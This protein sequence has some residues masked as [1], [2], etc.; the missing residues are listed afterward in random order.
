MADADKDVAG[1]IAPPPLIYVAGFALGWLLETRWPSPPLPAPAADW[2]GWTLIAAGVAVVVWS[3]VA[4]AQVKTSVNPYSPTAAIA[5]SGPYQYSRNPIYVA[6]IVIYIGFCALF[7]MLWPLAILPVV[8]IVLH[9]GVVERE[10]RYL[11]RRFGQLY[12]VY[13]S[14]VRRWI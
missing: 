10:E 14:R 3:I 11:E 5:T 6:D 1:V 4:M 12:A 7:D 13:C 2:I 9:K 8:V